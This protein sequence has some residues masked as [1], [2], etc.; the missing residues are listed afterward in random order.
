MRADLLNFPRTGLTLRGTARRRP[1][2]EDAMKAHTGDRLI[3]EGA[4][5]GNPRRTGVVLEVRGDN[6]APPYLVRWLDSGHETLCY[7]GPDAHIQ[8]EAEASAG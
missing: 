6:G 8:P 7:P 2:E 1:R 4:H 3:M 5:V